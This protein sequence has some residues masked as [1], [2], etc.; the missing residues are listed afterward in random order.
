MTY[1]AYQPMT[2]DDLTEVI[3]IEREC[4]GGYWQRRVFEEEIKQHSQRLWILRTEDAVVG[5]SGLWR[6]LEEAHLTTLAVAPA[7]RQK[8][9]GEVLLWLALQRC[10]QDQAHWLI[11]E[12]RPS[13]STALHLY[14]KYS[15]VQIGR[16]KHYYPDDE[17]ALVL[18]R[19]EIQTA[20]FRALIEER[21]QIV[22]TKLTTE[23]FKNTLIL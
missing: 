19:P 7:W 17:D 6:V 8:G 12:V 20:L 11:L 5:Y 21:K 13:N 2:L 18:W 3:A 9:L 14:K 4:F 16:R 15:F 22:L 23:G 10:Y 1:L